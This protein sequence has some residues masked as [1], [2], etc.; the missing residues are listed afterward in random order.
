[1]QRKESSKSVMHHAKL[2]EKSKSKSKKS[3]VHISQS[4][5]SSPKD[6]TK[7][8]RRRSKIFKESDCDYDSLCLS[9]ESFNEQ[10]QNKYQN[11][12]S[13]LFF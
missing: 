7:K 3:I 5:K 13:I 12:K 6:E 9:Y 2:H 1:M 11:E 10:S 4:P 8:Q